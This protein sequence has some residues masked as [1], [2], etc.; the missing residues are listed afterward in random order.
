MYLNVAQKVKISIHLL[1]GP[2]YIIKNNKNQN[3]PLF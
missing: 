2:I 1:S 3:T